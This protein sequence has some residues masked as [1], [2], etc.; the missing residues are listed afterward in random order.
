MAYDELYGDVDIEG[1]EWV[2]GEDE[3]GRV[4]KV[5]RPKGGRRLVKPQFQ[6]MQSNRIEPLPIGQ[7]AYV[8][9]GTL[10]QLV[11]YPQ[12]KF[13][14]LR[15]II[16]DDTSGSETITASGYTIIDIK[17]GSVSQLNNDGNLPGAL[18]SPTA[19]GT[20]FSFGTAHVG[21]QVRINAVHGGLL[22]HAFTG[23]FIGKSYFV[24]ES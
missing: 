1:D 12:R 22:Y 10:M 4:T 13:K 19:V 11:A 18:F 16:N 3:F 8:L 24:S 6:T 15:L 7:T 9:S 20:S 23:A 21:N 5:R 17:I 14:P 2:V